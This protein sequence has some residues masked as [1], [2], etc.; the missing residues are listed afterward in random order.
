MQD[1]VPLIEANWLAFTLVLVL[2][3]LVA[4]WLWGR[5]R[6]STRVRHRAPDALDEGAAP[7]QRNQALI[8]A[9]SAVTVAR[10]ADTGPDIMAG[11][12]EA[13]AL[14]AAKEVAAAPPPPSPAPPAS[15]PPAAVKPVSAPAPKP[16]KAPKAKAPAKPKTKA[17][18]KPKSAPKAKAEP[19]PKSEPKPKA[20]AKPA[21]A[22]KPKAAT[23][24][25]AAAKAKP[26]PVVAPE[27]V[28]ESPAA[29]ATPS[30]GPD[31]LSRIKGL[32][33][34]LQALLPTLGVTSFAQI[35][36]WNEAEIDRIDAQLGVFQGRIRKD[37][38][39]EQ[40]KLLAGGDVAAYEAKFGKL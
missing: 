6:K 23:K 28:V 18:P 31:D 8:D 4:W 30:G 14:G 5:G 40:A 3:L 7:A 16:A 10:M 24:P 9:P 36:G 34:K 22:P 2:A 33:P 15:P 21:A 25:K 13:I 27:P 11:M 17:E 35:A 39:V 19:K 1:V 20:A 12:G 38:W 37:N 29:P 32:G 26:A